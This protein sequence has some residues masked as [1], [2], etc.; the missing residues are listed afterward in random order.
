MMH[1]FDSTVGQMW[2]QTIQ[3]A[4]TRAHIAFGD[5]SSATVVSNLTFSPSDLAVAFT[6]AAEKYGLPVGNFRMNSDDMEDHFAGYYPDRFPP[7]P[8][9]ASDLV[10]NVFGD[11][12]IN[13]ID[14]SAKHSTHTFT[15]ELRQ[16]VGHKHVDIQVGPGWTSGEI[17]TAI[18]DTKHNIRQCH[19]EGLTTLG[20]IFWN[21]SEFFQ[22]KTGDE[23]SEPISDADTARA[24]EAFESMQ[25]ELAGCV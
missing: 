17:L 4:L 23:D 16:I 12:T 11:L 5:V 19:I 20:V 22:D 21:M 1:S 13:L 7:V 9:S 3:T 8:L 14:K 15:R 2:V 10:I 24:Y 18:A 6:E 25:V